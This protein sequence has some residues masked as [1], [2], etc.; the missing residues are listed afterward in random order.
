MV[1]V[2]ICGLTEPAGLEAALAADA[3]FIGL[4]FHPK[5]P[6]NV[7]LEAAAALARRARGRSEIVAVTV[8]ADDA[9][10]AAIAR[11]VAPD[12]IQ[13]HGGESPARLAHLKR[14]AAR[15]VMK[16]LPI[17]R[18]E[19]FAAMPAYAGVADLFLFDAKAP[20]DAALPG[21]NGAAFDW[22]LLR[23]VRP[24]RPWLLSGGLTPANVKAAIRETG[25]EAVDVSS[26]VERAPGLKDPTLVVAFAAEA[27][28]ALAA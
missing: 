21:G 4:V 19:D 22:R 5:S 7:G 26:G 16:A 23:D 11:H 12:W 28:T 13:A 3:R 10:V 25:A 14:Y 6:R 24:P 1:A 15:G 8:D 2:K 9:L 18:A 27:A 20:Q 17:A